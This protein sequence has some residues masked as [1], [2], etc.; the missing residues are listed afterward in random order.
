MLLVRNR[1]KRL[2]LGGLTLLLL[3]LAICS[4]AVGP[5]RISFLQITALVGSRLGWLTGEFDFSPY[6]EE[7]LWS[8]LWSIRL[9]RVLLSLFVGAALAVAG[10]GMQGLF[11]NPLADPSLIGVSAG[12]AVGGVFIIGFRDSI[13]GWSLRWLGAFAVPVFAF[14]GGVATTY[15]VYQISKVEGKTVVATMLLTGIAINAL[16]AAIIGFILITSNNDELRDF[17][18][19]S[20]GSLSGATWKSLAA[21][22]PFLLIPLSVYPF[23]WRALNAFLLGEAE[24]F[25]LGVDT[26]RTKG[27]L[28][29]LSAAMVGAT[30]AICGIIGFVGLVIP[31][32]VRICIGPDH[33]FLI[34]GSALLGAVLLLGTDLISRL[35]M[36]PGELP[37][38]IVTALLGAPFFLGLVYYSRARIWS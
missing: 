18:F 26:Q 38:G 25:H 6:N 1:H 37:I 5:V 33:R 31:H 35:A 20:L 13:A 28:V 17:T 3:I 8:I 9:P 24:A 16:A 27:A 19:W 23:F 11:R 14:I 12:A 34:P 2:Y 30:V 36:A 15:L 7:T 4:F 10:A 22:A 29:F 21:V 32:I